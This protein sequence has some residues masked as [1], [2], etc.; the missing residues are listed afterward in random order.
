MVVL[1]GRGGS[2]VCSGRVP[3]PGGAPGLPVT[4]LGGGSGGPRTLRERAKKPKALPPR[5]GGCLGTAS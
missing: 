3:P 1:G 4:S 5:E 2:P